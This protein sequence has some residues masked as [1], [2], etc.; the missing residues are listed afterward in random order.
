MKY[1]G[2]ENDDLRD[3]YYSRVGPFLKQENSFGGFDETE[4]LFAVIVNVKY[5]ENENM[6]FE[7]MLKSQGNKKIDA[8]VRLMKHLGKDE[9]PAILRTTEYWEMKMITV[10]PKYRRSGVVKELI[11]KTIELAKRKNIEKLV[12]FQTYEQP[13]DNPLGLYVIKRIQ[14]SEYTD[15]VTGKNIFSGLNPPNHVQ[16]MYGYNVQENNNNTSEHFTDVASTS[17]N[18]R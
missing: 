1:L 8:I 17:S 2:V 9:L 15:S 5:E 3:T 7:K 4:Q 10:H 18:I 6:N 12:C 13:P 11:R 14:L 16:I